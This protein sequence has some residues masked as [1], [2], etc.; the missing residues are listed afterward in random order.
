MRSNNDAGAMMFVLLCELLVFIPI[1]VIMIV[2]MWKIFKKAGL[3]GWECI[4]PF[5]GTY[6]MV[7]K[8]AGKDSNHF[9]LHLIP[10]VNIYARIVT[11]IAVSKSFG[12][13]DGFGFGLFFLG[14]IFWPWLAFSKT[15][16]FIGPGGVVANPDS[17]NS[18]TKDWQ[19]PDKP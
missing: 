5:Y 2:S 18:L 15:I 1:I 12:K 10:L 11:Y 14:I 17:S 13:D 4:V 19:N 9:V 6:M 7:T 3:E 8:I 16:N